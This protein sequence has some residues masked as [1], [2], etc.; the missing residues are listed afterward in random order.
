MHSFELIG[1]SG[2]AGTGKDYIAQDVLRPL[3]YHQFS[4]AW[5]P[6]VF[7]IAK[8]VATYEEVFHTKPPW[9]RD[10]MQQGFT[11]G[12]RDVYGDDIWADTM[13]TW[14]TVL[15]EYWGLTKF[16]IPDVRF[17]NEARAI[18]RVG[19]KV[20]RIHAPYRAANSNLTIEQRTHS[21][22]IALDDYTEFDGLIY[23]DPEVSDTAPKQLHFLLSV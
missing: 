15:A 12:G 20:F 19:G 3:G 16:M 4:F 8:K 18:R 13:F 6:K 10:L 7:M 17:P 14:F 5:H 23:N 2:K 9:V 1:L 11:E 21:G 22:E